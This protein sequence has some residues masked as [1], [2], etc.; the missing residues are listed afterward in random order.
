MKTFPKS[1][2]ECFHRNSQK[3]G[4]M[5][6]GKFWFDQG[7]RHCVHHRCDV[8]RCGADRQ[9]RLSQ[10]RRQSGPSKAEGRPSKA[11]VEPDFDDLKLDD[12]YYRD[13]RTFPNIQHS[14]LYPQ[15]RMAS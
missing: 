10:F 15:D 5:H 9:K 14:S 11:V 2:S 1:G 13:V 7:H 3:Q 6:L 8:Q 12:Q 4:H